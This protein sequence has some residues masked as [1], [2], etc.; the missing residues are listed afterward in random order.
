VLG[1]GVMCSGGVCVVCLGDFWVWVMVVFF[2]GV[3]GGGWV[4]F[5]L[6]VGVVACG[7]WCLT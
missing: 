2:V 1:L 5:V 3:G 4:G 6:V 7:F